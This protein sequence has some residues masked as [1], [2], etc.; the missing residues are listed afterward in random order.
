MLCQPLSQ[1]KSNID[2]FLSSM[3]AIPVQVSNA[4]TVHVRK[5]G[6]SRKWRAHVLCEGKICDLALL[7]VNSSEFWADDLMPLQFVDVPELQVTLAGPYSRAA[8]CSANPAC[9]VCPTAGIGLIMAGTALSSLS[10]CEHVVNVRLAA[11]TQDSILVAGYP[12]GGDSLSITK[13]IVSRVTMTR[14][15]HASHKLLGIQIDA[16]INPGNSGGPSFTDLQHGKVG[17]CS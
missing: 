3:L 15:T 8:C 5:P 4:T 9:S 14:Y 10:Q 7:S 6:N 2:E 16:A 13:G 17:T 11:L 12:L 1:I